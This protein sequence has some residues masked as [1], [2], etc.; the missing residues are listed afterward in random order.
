[1]N[2]GKKLDEEIKKKKEIK[3]LNRDDAREEL[4][5]KEKRERKNEQRDNH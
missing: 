1:M 4:I 2:E 3:E 5:K